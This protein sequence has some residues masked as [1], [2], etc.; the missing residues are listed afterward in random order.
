MAILAAVRRRRDA[1]ARAA[2]R[3]VGRQGRASARPA[4]FVGQQA[5]QLHGGM[6]VTDEL[7]ASHFQAPRHD[8]H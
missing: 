1:D 2:P 8:R 5:V 7:P 6:G 4:R 3:G